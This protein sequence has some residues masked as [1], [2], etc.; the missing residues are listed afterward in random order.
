MLF[1][2][3]IQ[4]TVRFLGRFARLIPLPVFTVKYPRKAMPVVGLAMLH[5]PCLRLPGESVNLAG[6]QDLQL[7]R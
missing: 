7:A 3:C 1:W 5:R 6:Y 2:K 4:V